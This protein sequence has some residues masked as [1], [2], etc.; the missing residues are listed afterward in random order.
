[1][2]FC[3]GIITSQNI[4]LI[5]KCNKTTIAYTLEKN[6]FLQKDKIINTNYFYLEPF[7]LKEKLSLNH[8]ETLKAL[9]VPKVNKNC[10]E[11]LKLMAFETYVPESE[12]S[13]TGA[14]Y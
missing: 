9:P 7:H 8:L 13:K 1:M 5:L 6:I 10:W 12:T 4:N 14:G 2:N 11:R 3:V